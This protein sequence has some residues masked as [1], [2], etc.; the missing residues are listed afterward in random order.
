MKNFTI[1][2]YKFFYLLFLIPGLFVRSE[3]SDG[4]YMHLKDQ[5]D[6]DSFKSVFQTTI[7]SG[8]KEIGA[9]FL[10]PKHKE[11][12]KI[13]SQAAQPIE[14][15]FSSKTGCYYCV[16]PNGLPRQEVCPPYTCND[17]RSGTL[18]FLPRQ[19]PV[20]NINPTQS[21]SKPPQ[22]SQP[23]NA[24]SNKVAMVKPVTNTPVSAGNK[25]DSIL[26]DLLL[27]NP[28]NAKSPSKKIR[29]ITVTK[30]TGDNNSLDSLKKLNP[31][32][33]KKIE[34]ILKSSG[35]A[36][37]WSVTDD[38]SKIEQHSM[39]NWKSMYNNIKDEL[40][41]FETLKEIRSGE[42]LGI[43]TYIHRAK[44]YMNEYADRFRR[45][46][47]AMND[48]K[49]KMNSSHDQGTRDMYMTKFNKAKTE[50]D[51][52]MDDYKELRDWVSNVV[53]SFANLFSPLNTRS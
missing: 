13:V 12:G 3:K 30:G 2:V 31:E 44:L 14:D 47:K 49:I 34:D 26:N 18:K 46:L 41:V 48:Y 19:Q 6:I 28:P 9:H 23:P 25:E 8:L 32:I 43:E 4:I 24:N 10:R 35:I 52:T 5:K 53:K 16:S 50:S 15:I 36:R 7:R 11:V 20:N 22:P 17:Y 27:P 39:P 45:Y 29:E 37:P 33:A 42:F 51:K 21:P 1:E 38:L 40:S